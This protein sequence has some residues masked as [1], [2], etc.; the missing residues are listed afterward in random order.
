VWA[1]LVLMYAV[2]A[3]G[4]GA[5]VGTGGWSHDTHVPALLVLMYAVVFV[6]F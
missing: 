4:G 3:C 2:V 5:C 6:C 1:L